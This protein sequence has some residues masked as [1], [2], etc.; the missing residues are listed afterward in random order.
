MWNM[1]MKFPPTQ[2]SRRYPSP[3]ISNT[4]QTGPVSG[5]IYVGVCCWFVI[6]SCIHWY[7][8]S[9][10][11]RFSPGLW[12]IHW[13]NYPV[14]DPARFLDSG[15]DPECKQ[16]TTLWHKIGGW[17]AWSGPRTPDG[18]GHPACLYFVYSWKSHMLCRKNPIWVKSFDFY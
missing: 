7:T 17:V 3:D 16:D 9:L 8:I 1:L 6:I 14:P 18:P 10:L 13:E 4:D 5:L 15:P 12:K 11:A 2:T